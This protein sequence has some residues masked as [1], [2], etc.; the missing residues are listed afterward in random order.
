MNLP[1]F[2]HAID[3]RQDGLMWASLPSRMYGY[4][5]MTLA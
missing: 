3:M 2:A 5:Q 1:R 4:A